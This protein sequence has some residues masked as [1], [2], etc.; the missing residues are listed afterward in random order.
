[1]EITNNNC[2]KLATAFGD[3]FLHPIQR[4]NG[5]F[6]D[7]YES[8]EEYV[9]SWAGYYTACSTFGYLLGA[10]IAAHIWKRR[11]DTGK[12]AVL[13]PRSGKWFSNNFVLKPGSISFRRS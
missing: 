7:D 1:M 6:N 4:L 10:T 8:T 3:G 13:D 11:F 5:S 9:A 2:K 12:V